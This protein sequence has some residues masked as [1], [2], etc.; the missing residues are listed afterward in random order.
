MIDVIHKTCGE[1]AFRMKSRPVPGKV[2]RSTDAYLL[3]GSHPTEGSIFMCDSC[4]QPVE[5]VHCLSFKEE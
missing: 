3:D 2:M 4:K 5:N 1:V